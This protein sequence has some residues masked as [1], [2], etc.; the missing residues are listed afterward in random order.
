M[1][2]K[3]YTILS[4]NILYIVY[5]YNFTIDFLFLPFFNNLPLVIYGIQK[6]FGEYRH[7]NLK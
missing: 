1:L 2:V 5:H 7:G 6:Y 3:H 4:F